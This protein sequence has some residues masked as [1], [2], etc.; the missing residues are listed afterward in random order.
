MYKHALRLAKCT[1]GEAQMRREHVAL[2]QHKAHCGFACSCTSRLQ[3]TKS[4][5]ISNLP[6]NGAVAREIKRMSQ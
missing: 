3:S 6:A 5:T 2:S 4:R 1:E